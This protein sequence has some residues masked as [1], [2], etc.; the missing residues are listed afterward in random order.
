V[1]NN[2]SFS[3][4]VAVALV[5]LVIACNRVEYHK[6]EKDSEV[7][8]IS[9]E[10][11]K[12]AYD[13]GKAVIVDSRAEVTYQQEH[14]AGAINIPIGSGDEKFSQLPKGKKIIVYCS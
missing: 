2:R 11:A 5:A 8:R 1:K 7:P 14:I 3:L 4:G 13:A 9:L 10:D 12:A 6:F